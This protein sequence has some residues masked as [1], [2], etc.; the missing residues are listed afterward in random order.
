MKNKTESTDNQG[1]NI[2]KKLE[3]LLKVRK[4]QK[5][6]FAK[7]TGKSRNQVYN[8]IDSKHANTEQILLWSDLLEVSVDYWFKDNQGVIVQ[9]NGNLNKLKNVANSK[10]NE[11]FELKYKLE[12]KDKEI[13]LLRAL[14]KSKDEIIGTLRGN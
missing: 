6:E 1:I 9:I 4:I 12:A 13:D 3:E 11:L 8:W 10:A 14:L 7:M 5:A 2:G